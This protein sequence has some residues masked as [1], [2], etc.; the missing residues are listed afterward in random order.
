[1]DNHSWHEGLKHHYLVNI[2]KRSV[3][4]INYNGGREKL[5]TT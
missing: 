4:E 3:N 2:E 5:N 1:M